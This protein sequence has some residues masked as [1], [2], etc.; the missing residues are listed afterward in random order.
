M[1]VNDI[2]RGVGIREGAESVATLLTRMCLRS[3][4][5][6]GGK[7]VKIEIPPT[8]AGG[9]VCVC[10]WVCMCVLVGVYVCVGGCV[11]V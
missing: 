11:L 5:I 8:R 3:E 10:W 7:S 6:E 9:C 2:N 1:T 4:V